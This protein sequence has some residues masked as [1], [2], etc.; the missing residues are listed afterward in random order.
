MQTYMI[1]PLPNEPTHQSWVFVKCFNV[2]PQSSWTISHSMC[3]FTPVIMRLALHSTFTS[4][5]CHHIS[6]HHHESLQLGQLCR[7]DLH[8]KRLFPALG[9][10]CKL[11]NIVTRR[12]HP[13]VNINGLRLLISFVMYEP[14]W[15]ICLDE[16]IH[17]HCIS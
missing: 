2:F 8:Y 14:G 1:C 4:T 11:N 15:I 13:A 10:V 7:V 6:T 9:F 5:Y 12:I 16:I 3:I 17:L